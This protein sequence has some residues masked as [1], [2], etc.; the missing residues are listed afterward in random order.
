M[1]SCWW[2]KMLMV[3]WLRLVVAFWPNQNLRGFGLITVIITNEKKRLCS[4]IYVSCILIYIYICYV[5]TDLFISNY[6]KF[7]SSLQSSGLTTTRGGWVGQNLSRCWL[8]WRCVSRR[9]EGTMGWRTRSRRWTWAWCHR[10]TNHLSNWHG[11]IVLLCHTYLE[12]CNYSMV[13]QLYCKL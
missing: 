5:Y 7:S 10:R 9:D 1:D 13:W 11:Y 6:S 12:Y 8:L 2:T 4:I 3:Q